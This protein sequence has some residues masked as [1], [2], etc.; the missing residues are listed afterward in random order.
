MQIITEAFHTGSLLLL[1]ALSYYLIYYSTKLFQVSHAAVITSGAYFCLLFMKTFGIPLPMAFFL[2]VL[3]SMLLGSLLEVGLY[4]RMRVNGL[5]SLS[6]LIASLGIYVVL[7]NSIAL[8]ASDDRRSLF[9]GDITIG[10]NFFGGYV[11][12]LQGWTMCVAVMLFG[13]TGLFLRFSSGGKA[14]RAVSSNAELSTIYGIS[15]NKTILI[16]TCVGSALGAIAGILTALDV[17][18][19]PAFG[20]D[21]LLYGIVAMIIGGVGSVKGLMAGSFIVAFAQQGAAYF[22]DTRWLD[23]IAY[24]I[25]IGFLIWKPLGFSGKLIRK[26]EI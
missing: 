26:V 22:L 19:S 15:V 20:F 4:R 3:C 13:F 14:I 10:Y 23:A 6:Y 5:S 12:S 21:L 8:I 7:L 24:V 17:G 16:A 2:A 1:V 11:S 9:V 25:L 18:V